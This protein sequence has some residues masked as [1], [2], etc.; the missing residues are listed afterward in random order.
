MWRVLIGCS[1]RSVAGLSNCAGANSRASAADAEGRGFCLPAN[2]EV[3]AIFGATFWP[4]LRD[5]APTV[6]RTRVTGRLGEVKNPGT[7]RVFRERL[8]GLEPTT[9]CMAIVCDFRI[10]ASLRGFR[11]NPITGDY[12]GFG[13]YWSPGARC[14]AAYGSAD[15]ALRDESGR[16]TRVPIASWTSRAIWTRLSTS[17]LSSSRD[18]WA[19]TVGTERCRAAAISALA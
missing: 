7:C 19:L 18:T 3:L 14:R 17:S 13:G 10:N 6:C 5:Y 15:H 4:R 8:M 9:F 2:R 1:R 12:R 11:L 16:S